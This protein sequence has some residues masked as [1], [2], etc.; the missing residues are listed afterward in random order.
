[1]RDMRVRSPRALAGKRTATDVMEA[2]ALTELLPARH[3]NM[4]SGARLRR[5]TAAQGRLFASEE[6]AVVPNLS[7][8]IVT[9]PRCSSASTY[10]RRVD[11]T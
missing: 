1:L 5:I 7:F 2:V 4:P 10:M 3:R 8:P 6:V 11:W 9:D